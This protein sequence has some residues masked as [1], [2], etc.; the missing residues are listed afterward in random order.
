M[1][2][3]VSLV[4]PLIAV[5]ALSAAPPTEVTIHDDKPFPES[6]TS[7]SDGTLIIGGLNK[8]VVYRAAKGASTAELWIKPDTNGL[9]RVLGVLAD[10][11]SN[12]LWVCSAK[13]PNATAPTA[14]KTFDLKTGAS[15]GSYDFPAPD[16]ALCND[17]AIGPD[18]SA[19][20]SDTL[21]NRIL[22]LKKGASALDVWVKDD[23]LAGADGIAFGDN[24]TIYVNTVT[25]NRF[26]RV[27]INKDGSA[28][29][30]AELKP[31]Q[32]LSSPDGMRALGNN[33]FLM[34]EGAG[35][36]DHVTVSGNDAKIEVLKDG[37]KGPTAVTRIGNNAWV[38]EGKLNYM[39]DP[40]LKDQDPGPFKAYAVPFPAKH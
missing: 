1:K 20:L 10:Q 18:G 7:T 17:I 22:R 12:T 38:I 2:L 23:K 21:A 39:N 40:K 19:Y 37:F 35:R 3:L 32:A 6:V 14:V 9:Q 5:S 26:F 34:I 33:Q 36:L 4:A 27:P 8:G 16:N 28:G 31:S 30:V 13:R 15:K 11:K 29:A 25:T 24:S